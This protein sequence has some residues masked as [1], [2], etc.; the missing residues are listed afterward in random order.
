MYKLKQSNEN[1]QNSQNE[2]QQKSI[3][4]NFISEKSSNLLNHNSKEKQS[5]DKPNFKSNNNI[6]NNNEFTSHSNRNFKDYDMNSK[7]KIRN[8]LIETK[9]SEYDNLNQK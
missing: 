9:K 8:N 1:D 4:N 5:P 6:D 3:I 2:L 7:N